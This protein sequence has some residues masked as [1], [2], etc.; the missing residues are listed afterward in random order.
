MLWVAGGLL[1]WT[2]LLKSCDNRMRYKMTVEVETPEGVKSGFSVREIDHQKPG[3]FPFPLGESRPQWYLTGEAVAV[4]LPGRRTLFALLTGRNGDVDY[5]GHGIWTVFKVMDRDIGPKGG[6]HE[7]WPKVPVI[8][9]PITDP[10]PMLAT[11]ADLSDPKSLTI[12]DPANLSAS[13]GPD[14]KLKRIVVQ[15]T[16]ESITQE[17][18]QRL[19]KDFFASWS[20]FQQS[21]S[22]C[23]RLDHPYFRQPASTFG[24]RNFITGEY[25]PKPEDW[26]KTIRA[27]NARMAKYRDVSC[28][29]LIPD[30][31]G[32]KLQDRYASQ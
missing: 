8:R 18:L 5:A 11:F 14:V 3:W 30:W 16:S 32:G 31:K 21:I 22:H 4:D 7:L 10:L 29:S 17:I 28:E 9:E 13:F 20:Q 26:R 19:D 23:Y 15:R 27:E 2:L 6:P 1:G 25:K 24:R 12:I